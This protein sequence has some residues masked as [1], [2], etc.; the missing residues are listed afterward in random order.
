VF[1]WTTVSA[2]GQHTNPA[3]KFNFIIEFKFIRW[4]TQDLVS[5]KRHQRYLT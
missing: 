5:R 1:D 3:D 4:P 2:R